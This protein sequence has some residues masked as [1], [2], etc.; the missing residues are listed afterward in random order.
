MPV[1]SGFPASPDA[2]RDLVDAFIGAS[3][4]LVA[5]AARSL[6]GVD[7]DVTLPQYRAL[8]VLASRGPQRGS[9]LATAL[10]VNPSTVSRMIERLARRQLVRRTRDREDRRTVW[11]TLSDTGRRLVGEV[12][13]RRRLHIEGVLAQM[14]RAGRHD[15]IAALRAFAEATGEVPEQDWSLGWG[16]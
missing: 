16:E 12:T 8:V 2:D 13:N 15:L 10:G 6:T 14:P 1:S 4:A 7:E 3:R 11:I 9:D 5:V